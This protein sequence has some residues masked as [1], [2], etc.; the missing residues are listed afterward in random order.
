MG[1]WGAEYRIVAFLTLT[2]AQISLGKILIDSFSPMG[3]LALVG[4]QS[5]KNRK[6]QSNATKPRQ[7]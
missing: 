5:I 7:L 4:K 1:N 2:Y 6:Q 3:W